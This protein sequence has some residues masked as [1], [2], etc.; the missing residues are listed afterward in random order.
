MQVR[1]DLIKSL[2][3]QR[4]LKL[5]DVAAEI[6]VSTQTWN[7]WMFR[8]IFPHFNKIEEL[9]KFLGLEPY[10]LIDGQ[11]VS[12]PRSPYRN[13]VKIK[14]NAADAIP[15]F[16]LNISDNLSILMSGNLSF[17]AEDF[18]SIPGISAD[19]IMPYYGG[20]MESKI[21]SG[22][23]IALRRVSDTSFYIYGNIYLIGTDDQILL[24]YVKPGS[25]PNTITLMTENPKWDP[26]EL[27]LKSIRSA[28]LVVSIIKRQVN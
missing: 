3:K 1:K 6:G 15:F 5:K 16:D 13:K 21:S 23:L 8:G 11:F 25:K 19:L 22:D 20:E 10:E 27:P 7:N 9:A 26:I 14:V 2:I 18:I 4:S 17:V 24:R 12:E 28:H